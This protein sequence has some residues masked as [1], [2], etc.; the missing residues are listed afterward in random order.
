VNNLKVEDTKELEMMEMEEKN[1]KIIKKIGEV[2]KV[3]WLTSLKPDKF[4]CVLYLKEYV[5]FILRNVLCFTPCLAY[6][7]M[8]I[9]LKINKYFID[10]LILP[11]L[12]GLEVPMFHFTFCLTFILNY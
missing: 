8:N 4:M 12:K 3:A 11:K 5:N 6:N 10:I 1:E 7:R 2:K 9:F